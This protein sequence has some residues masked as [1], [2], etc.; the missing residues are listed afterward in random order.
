M[1]CTL[2]SLRGLG[3]AVALAAAAPGCLAH[4][5]ARAGAV[6]AGPPPPREE[7]VLYRPGYLWIQGHWVRGAS[8]PW[9]WQ[10]GHYARERP[11]HVYVQG[12]W[13]RR[14]GRYVWIEGLWRP[15]GRVVVQRR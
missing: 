7:V 8:Q 15:R 9:V 3:C 6:E 1:R 10:A 2:S 5:G 14:G 11:S 12:R 13:E 4:G